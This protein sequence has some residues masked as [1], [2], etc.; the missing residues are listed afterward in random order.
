MKLGNQH[1]EDTVGFRSKQA[2]L[3]SLEQTMDIFAGTIGFQRN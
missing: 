3:A 1:W 2:T